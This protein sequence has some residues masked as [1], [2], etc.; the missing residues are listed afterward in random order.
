MADYYSAAD[1]YVSA[2][3][4]EGS[5]YALIEALACGLTPVVT[6]IA[7]FRAIAGEVGARFAPGDADACAAA[8]AR[9][10]REDR[11]LLRRAA[12][13]RFE[14]ALTWKAIGDRAMTHYRALVAARTP[15]AM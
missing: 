2:S 14:A 1:V 8:L 13:A 9:V 4:S 12:R 5:G 3:R 6:D 10:A 7:P 15:R 11:D